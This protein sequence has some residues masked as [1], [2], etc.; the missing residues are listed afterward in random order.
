VLGLVP[1]L[2]MGWTANLGGQI[3]HSEIRAD[4]E[5]APPSLAGGP[6]AAGAEAGR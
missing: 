4:V 1:A 5:V 2:A 3:R 6:E